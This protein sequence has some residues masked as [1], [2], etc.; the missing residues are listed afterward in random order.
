MD[1]KEA[2]RRLEI[3]PSLAYKL[4]QEGRLPCVRIGQKGRRGKIVLTE[5]HLKQFMKELEEARGH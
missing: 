5:E 4:V 2:A 3:S 1:V